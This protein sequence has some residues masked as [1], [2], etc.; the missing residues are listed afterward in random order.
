MIKRTLGLS[1]LV[2]IAA[3]VCAWSQGAIPKP[4]QTST[5]T[6][7]LLI[8]DRAPETWTVVNST[9]IVRSLLSYKA[10]L[11]ILIVGFF[12][13]DCADNAAALPSIRRFENTYADWHV[14]FLWID[15]D[16]QD[17]SQAL[18]ETLQRAGVR[19]PVAWDAKHDLP[20]WLKITRTP[21]FLVF[22]ESAAVRYRGPLGEAAKSPMQ[23]PTGLWASI[24]KVIGHV[25]PVEEPEP[26]YASGGCALP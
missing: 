2:S 23:P 10:P 21:A 7:P 19:G 8:G 25:D 6:A 17:T 4:I 26:P 18:A 24:D 11:D 16:S 15:I 12:S 9:G 14:A 1:F 5:A 13:N 20:Y 3:C 22:D